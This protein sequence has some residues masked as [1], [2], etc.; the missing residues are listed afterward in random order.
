MKRLIPVLVSALFAGTLLHAKCDDNAERLAEAY[1]QIKACQHNKIIWQDGSSMPYDDGKRETFDKILKRADIEDMFT[2]SYLRG[3]Y[4]H[5]PK[6]YDPGRYR[7][8]RFFRKMYGNA[9]SAVK[10]RLTTIHWFGQPVKVTTVNHVHRHLQAVE[11]ELK[12]LLKTHPDYKKYL[13]PIGG[14]FKWRK[15]AGTQR[16]SVHSFGAAI[17]IHVKY[18]AYWRWSK[19]GYRYRNQI[20]KAIVRIFEKH[21]FIWGGKWYHYDTMHFEYRPELL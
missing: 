15:I 9:A 13:T 17:D 4:S 21:D 19:G 1:P 2:H 20:L 12:K 3:L 16:L 10:K 8:E 14:T 18:S 5:P 6:N 7:N 11:K